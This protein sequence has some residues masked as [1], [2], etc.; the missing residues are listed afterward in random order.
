MSSEFESLNV[1]ANQSNFSRLVGTSQPAIKAHF[2]KGTLIA[3]QSLA[4]WLL[5]YCEALRIEAAGRGGDDQKSLT[6]ARTRDA[7]QS[8]D[9]KEIMIAEKL[10]TLVIVE[11]IEPQFL[12]MVTAARMELLSIP[13]KVAAEIKSLHGIDVDAKLIEEHIY[14]SLE[15]LSGG[16]H[17]N[18]E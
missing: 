6:R 1:K 18:A 16:L 9:L 8:A 13:M 14:E 7:E 2:D 5:Q 17:K 10:G 11:D 3:G 15:H 12:A 4:N